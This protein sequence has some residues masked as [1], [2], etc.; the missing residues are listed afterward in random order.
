MLS[1]YSETPATLDSVPK[2]VDERAGK[3]Q[4]RCDSEV[5]V[6]MLWTAFDHRSMFGEKLGLGPK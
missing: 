5:T 1:L 6:A 3:P 2:G 4:E